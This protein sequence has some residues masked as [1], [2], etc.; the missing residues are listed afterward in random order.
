[1]SLAALFSATA[2][3]VGQEAPADTA[4]RMPLPLRDLYADTWVAADAL[5]RTMP[6]ASEVG[7]PK[8]D[9]ER[10]V[11]IFYITWHLEHY[12]K[13]PR[14]PYLSVDDVL[15]AHP[16]ARLD[17]TDPAWKHHT[18]YNHWGEPENG[19][20][21]SR[22]TYVIRKDISMLAD[23]GVDVLILDVTNAV[24]YWDQWETLLQV[25]TE[26]RA[27]GNRVPQFCFWSYNGVSITVVQDLYDRIYKQNKYRDFWFMWDGKPLLLYNAHPEFDAN[28][29]GIQHPNPHYDQDARTN[30]SNPHYNDPDYIHPYYE[31]YTR[32][33]KNFFTLRNMWWGYYEW[34]G[35]RFIG[36]EGNW[37]FGYDLGDKRV[38]A[39]PSD[40]LV[41][42]WRGRLEEAAVTAAQHPVSQI[43]KSW[44]RE[45]GEPPLNQYDMPDSAYVPYL[46]RK[47]ADPTA[48]G[49]YFQERWDEALKADPQFIYLNDWNEWIA[50]MYPT[51]KGTPTHFLGRESNFFYVDQY[52]AEFNRTIQPMKGGYTD[53][54]YMQM[55]QNIRRYKGARPIPLHHAWHTPKIDGGFD[56]WESVADDYRDTRGDTSHRD[57]DGYFGLHYTDSLGRND[58]LT[59]KVASDRQ[60]AYFYVETASA[61]TPHADEAWML[62]FIDA[63]CNPSTGW[64]GYDYVV[65]RQVIDDHRTV[66]LKYD[67]SHAV[68]QWKA[69]ARLPYAYRGNKLE[70]KIPFRLLGIRSAND[71]AFDF[72][73]CDHPGDLVDPIS[74]ATAGD[75]APNRRFNYRYIFRKESK[76]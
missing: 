76:E 29:A 42:P 51:E 31:D 8:Q 14:P 41:A 7:L 52:N 64:N 40:S 5:G 48:Y 26:M 19:Y 24:R 57:H 60:A 32:E 37:S 66:L 46:G 43:G 28:R 68:P 55:A 38:K 69:V 53:N 16:E 18:A 23:A 47:V 30:T 45:F 72:K 75:T 73:W 9:H 61:L 70:L 17:R 50:G 6:S 59:A 34:G 4:R 15:K 20:F 49:I 35:R 36:T 74:L 2:S 63:D 10:T 3:L 13:L 44:S 22:D 71:F 25:M 39:M 56:D 27:E 11:G 65:N 58:I 62:L 67:A 21:L 1:M 54:Y 12:H 33:V